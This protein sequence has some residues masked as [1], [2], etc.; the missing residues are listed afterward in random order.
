[1]NLFAL[2]NDVAANDRC[3]DIG[4]L[5]A[6]DRYAALLDKPAGFAV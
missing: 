5:I 1:M 3:V 2:V 4:D 6:V